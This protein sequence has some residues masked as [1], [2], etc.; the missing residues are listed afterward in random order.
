[1]VRG[2]AVFD[3]PDFIKFAQCA[4]RAVPTGSEQII[5]FED[6]HRGKRR[7]GESYVKQERFEPTQFQ[8]HPEGG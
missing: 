3:A 6:A 7:V 2:P 5:A 8:W 1:M 4:G